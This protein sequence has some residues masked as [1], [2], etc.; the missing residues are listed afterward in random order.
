MP[1]DSWNPPVELSDFEQQWAKP[2]TRAR[3]MYVFLRKIRSQLFDAEMIE[4]LQILHEAKP[5]GKE[6]K[7]AAQMAMLLLLQAYDGCSDEVAVYRSVDDIKYKIVLD[8][9]D[10]TKPICSDSTLCEFRKKFIKHDLDKVLLERTIRLAKETGL[11]G[12]TSLKKMKIVVD[13]APLEGAGKVLDSINLLGTTL[14]ALVTI[15]ASLLAVP[16]MQLIEHLNI[17]FLQAKSIKAGLDM[18][19]SQPGANDIALR[20]VLFSILHVHQ[21]IFK[22]GLSEHPL[23]QKQQQL[24]ETIYRQD[25]DFFSEEG[26]FQHRQGVAE[27][28]TISLTDSEMRHGRKSKHK[29]IQGYKKTIVVEKQTGIILEAVVLPANQ[30]DFK[31]LDKAVFEQGW[32]V[33][34]VDELFFDRGYVSAQLVQELIAIRPAGVLVKPHTYPERE[35][36]SKKDFVFDFE[37]KRV[38][39]PAGRWQVFQP[40]QKRVQYSKTECH[41]CPKRKECLPNK[42]PGG[43]VIHLHPKEEFQQQLKQRMQTKEGRAKNRERTVV[44][45]RISHHTGKQKARARYLGVRKN[46]F[47][48]RRRGAICNLFVIQRHLSST[49]ELQAA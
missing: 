49:N 27:D 47:D 6:P 41:S 3:K 26:I 5:R 19:W 42:S 29:T 28:R 2:K 32:K 31:G 8:R 46:D 16:Q 45:H 48:A 11:F 12:H 25:V 9:M 10:A 23:V 13:S 18:D 17:D 44:E 35:T 39:C 33:E 7:P 30:P 14:L 43:K 20:R 21:W 4:A 34:D 36:Y 1:I 38:R 15:V 40:E 24:L 22:K 37:Q